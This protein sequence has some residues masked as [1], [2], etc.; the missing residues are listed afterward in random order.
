[1]IEEC[2]WSTLRPEEIAQ[3]LTYDTFSA[4]GLERMLATVYGSSPFAALQ[5]LFPAVHPWQM[6]HTPQR[7]WQGESGRDHARAA[8]RWLLDHL[9]L[10]EADPA[11]IA[12]QID[13]TPFDHY[14]L[15]GMLGIVYEDSPYAAV[16]DLSPTLLPW[17]MVGGASTAYWRGKQGREHARSA[18]RWLIAQLGLTTADPEDVARRVT[19]DTFAA[20][21]LSGMLSKVYRD[22]PYAALVD[23]YPNLHPW[24]M[25][26]VPRNY[27]SGARG[28]EHAQAATRWLVTQLGLTAA[29][30]AELIT[31]LDQA[32]FARMHLAGMLEQVY[33]NNPYAA[34]VDLYPDLESE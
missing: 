5:D 34:V 9:G 14:G 27:W 23:V 22:S 31:Q 24:Q 8:T 4:H 12:A 28:R 26:R 15:R 11:Q 10:A 7:Y 2:G 30:Q 19:F 18:T 13:Q 33:G 20:H 25:G 21:D 16:A 29:T 3:R 1:M 32:T 6:K 17:Q